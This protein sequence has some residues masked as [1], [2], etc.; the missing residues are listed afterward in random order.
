VA[1]SASP[2]SAAR[3]ACVG[4]RLVPVREPDMSAGRCQPPGEP[5]ARGARY[6]SARARARRTPTR[7]RTSASLLRGGVLANART[8]SIVT[9]A[10][11]QDRSRRARPGTAAPRNPGVRQTETP[12]TGHTTIRFVCTLGSG[13]GFVPLH[14]ERG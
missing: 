6:S 4:I 13:A 1:M 14:I 5:P 2:A 9:T 7:P 8:S 12:R 10:R 3:V 11:S